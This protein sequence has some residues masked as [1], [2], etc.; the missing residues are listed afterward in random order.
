MKNKKLD[1]GKEV[2]GIVQKNTRTML[3][4]RQEAEKQKGVQQKFAA[5]VARYV[6]S[7]PFIYIQLFFI[8]SWVIINL[9]RVP[10][11]RQFDPYPF[12][13]L[14]LITTIEAI[15]L[16]VFILVSQNRMSDLEEKRE[17]LGLQISLLTE[18]EV[19]RLMNLVDS[20]ATHLKVTGKDQDLKDLKKDTSPEKVLNVIEAEMDK[21]E[22]KDPKN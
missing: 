10:G 21:I 15:F 11:L 19:T 14:A 6:G 7:M 8:A 5:L 4:L 1:S 3:E 22:K 2:S 20:I 12:P 13:L 17:E 9:K 18:H 16:A